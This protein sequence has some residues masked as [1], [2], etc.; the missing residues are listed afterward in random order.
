MSRG[1]HEIR[2]TL[3]PIGRFVLL[4]PRKGP[5]APPG[6]T[7]ELDK[8]VSMPVGSGCDGGWKLPLSWLAMT[9]TP[10]IAAR[11]SARLLREFGS[12]EGVFPGE[13][14]GAGGLQ[15]ARSGGAGDLQEAKFLASGKRSC[16]AAGRRREAHQL[17]G[18]AIPT[19]S[20]ADLRPTGDALRAG[21]RAN[22]E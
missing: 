17:D 8:M 12:P 20:A 21:R 16:R 1:V 4:N 13:L 9:M 6:I 3:T 19:A 14:D 5:S 2:R 15:P 18:A 11:L 10:G 22:P 7:E